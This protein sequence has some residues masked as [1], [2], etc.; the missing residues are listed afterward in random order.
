V[1]Q[2]DIDVNT[3]PEIMMVREIMRAPEVVEFV[4]HFEIL[5]AP[6]SRADHWKCVKITSFSSRPGAIC[7]VWIRYGLGTICGRGR[8]QECLVERERFSLLGLIGR[9][10][11]SCPHPLP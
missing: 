2:R 11:L 9:D 1:V 5:A 4:Q 3:A 8:N 6:S 10:A 7:L